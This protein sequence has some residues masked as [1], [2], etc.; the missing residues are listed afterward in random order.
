MKNFP[1]MP[2]FSASCHREPSPISTD[3][4]L[5]SN[6][7]A[8]M[9][10]AG[11]FL[12]PPL[13]ALFFGRGVMDQKQSYLLQAERELASRLLCSCCRTAIWSSFRDGCTG[14]PEQ[15]E[16]PQLGLHS[17]ALKRRIH[18]RIFFWYM[19][20]CTECI[21]ESCISFHTDLQ[22]S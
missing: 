21:V 19:V 10:L 20:F 17:V 3:S 5:P 22:D 12:P 2:G 14:E 4:L 18:R 6:C 1:D 16:D 9:G 11:T 7:L 15:G 8:R 13:P